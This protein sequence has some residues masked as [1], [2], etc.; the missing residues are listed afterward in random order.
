MVFKQFTVHDGM[1]AMK[2]GT[3]AV[4]L[5]V[6]ASHGSPKSIVDIGTGSGVVALMLSQR[7]P[8]SQTLGIELE[9]NAFKQALE[10]INASPF[11][12]RVSCIQSS[13]QDW[14]SDQSNI[15]SVD[16][17]VS[18]PPFFKNKPKSPVEA[19]NLA[20]HDD[21]L[22]IDEIFSG[23]SKTLR[24][25]GVLCVVWPE[26][27]KE[28]LIVA[29]SKAGFY[30]SK[31]WD[32]LPT[33]NHSSVRFVAEFSLKPCSPLQKDIILEIGEGQDREFTPEYLALMRDFFLKA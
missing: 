24:E 7:Y 15:D 6:L 8:S 10:N 19:R 5:G 27:R 18:N 1:C 30:L 28:D 21:S 9:P 32:I 33:V 2:I 4:V 3:D 20:R 22:K 11:S 17:L 29:A 25:S 23:A 31:K 13:F 26:E 12:E 16:L 14:V